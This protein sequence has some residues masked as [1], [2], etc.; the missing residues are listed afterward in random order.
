LQQLTNLDGTPLE[1]DS[2]KRSRVLDAE[3]F[4]LL[5]P[6]DA[7]KYEAAGAVYKRREECREFYTLGKVATD[8]LLNLQQGDKEAER[9]ARGR[10]AFKIAAAKGDMTITVDEAKDLKTVIGRLFG[11]LVVVQAFDM[12]EGKDRVPES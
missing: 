3:T 11:A 10:L 6:E 12:I 7:A 8:A 9:F 1:L 4:K 2:S 5:T